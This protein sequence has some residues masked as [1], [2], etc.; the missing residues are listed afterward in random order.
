MTVRNKVWV[1]T[2]TSLDWKGPYY[3]GV[4]TSLE[5]AQAACARYLNHAHMIRTPDIIWTWNG[6]DYMITGIYQEQRHGQAIG[7]MFDIHRTT[8]DINEIL[9]EFIT[10][11]D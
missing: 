2:H 11:A 6:S 8:P 9:S 5:N 3:L 1:A 4:F 7:S 10:T